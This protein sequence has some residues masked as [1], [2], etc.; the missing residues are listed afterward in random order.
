MS[1]FNLIST[2]SRVSVTGHTSPR[3]GCRFSVTPCGADGAITG[4]VGAACE[5]TCAPLLDLAL[6]NEMTEIS[7]QIG[8]IEI[9]GWLPWVLDH[10]AP[11]FDPS[12]S[13]AI[14]TVISRARAYDWRAKDKITVGTGCKL[15]VLPVPTVS[16]R[17][18]SYPVYLLWRCTASG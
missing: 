8:L 2:G 11:S 6:G 12:D 18:I 17:Y 7:G 4:T 14:L 5:L 1:R 3:G 9:S 13:L 15:S 16:P 10:D